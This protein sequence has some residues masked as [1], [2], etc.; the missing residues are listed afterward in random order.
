[1][2]STSSRCSAVTAVSRAMSAMPKMMFTGVRRS[3]L[4]LATKSRRAWLACSAASLA[5][6]QLLLGEE[7]AV[8]IAVGED[9]RRHRQPTE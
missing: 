7:Q 5:T 3:W 2:V 6:L 9:G 4:T 8:A 1:M